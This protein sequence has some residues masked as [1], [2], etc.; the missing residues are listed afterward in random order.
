MHGTTNNPETKSGC[1]LQNSAIHGRHIWVLLIAIWVCLVSGWGDK[2]IAQS[3]KPL[4]LEYASDVEWLSEVI[5]KSKLP[6]SHEAESFDV[7]P[8]LKP[9]QSDTLIG[10][11]AERQ[12]IREWWKNYLGYDPE[13][14]REL[15]LVEVLSTTVDQ[16]VVR[17]HWR[18]RTHGEWV[19]EAFLLY[20]SSPDASDEHS[21][22]MPLRP[23]AVVLHPTV[24]MSIDE[25]AGVRSS[26]GIAHGP[27]ALGWHLA[28]LGFVVICP[29]NYLWPANDRIEAAAQSDLWKQL[30]LSQEGTSKMLGMGK[31][32]YD[33]QVAADLLLD[34]G[35]ADPNQLSVLGHS[36]GAKEA[37]YA[38]ALDERFRAGAASEG[39]IGIGF[40]NWD[41]E[42]YLGSEVKHSSFSH[43]HHELLALIA[44]RAFLVVAGDSA[45]GERGWPLLVEAQSRYSLYGAR[46]RLGQFNHRQGHPLNESGSQRM[47]EWVDIY[48]RM[49]SIKGSKREL[50]P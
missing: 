24:D 26:D 14:R 21:S 50:E 25:P 17:E 33:V 4:S 2:A 13:A 30:R 40:S 47:L 6:S 39:G 23:A 16:G 38:M 27:R 48:G 22:E 43:E 19:T 12:R 37:L 44:P 35:K 18:Y 3:P 36:L 9:L 41:A 29:R 49:T 11:N 42:W 20:P 45:D 7:V 32:L 8:N 28:K 34:H 46:N 10:W 15:P 31:M 1:H 5:A